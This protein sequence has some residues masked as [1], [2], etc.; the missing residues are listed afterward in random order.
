MSLLIATFFTT[1]VLAE[2]W[3]YQ[4]KPTS[5]VTGTTYRIEATNPY[6]VKEPFDK[7]SLTFT[8]THDDGTTVTGNIVRQGTDCY[9]PHN[10]QTR[11]YFDKINIRMSTKF[12]DSGQRPKSLTDLTCTDYADAECPEG[13]SVDIFTGECVTSD[14]EPDPD[15][16]TSGGD[17]GSGDGSDGG[18]S[19]GSGSS[20]PYA[21]DSSDSCLTQAQNQ[22]ADGR[23]LMNYNYLGGSVYRF[24][25]GYQDY[26]CGDNATWDKKHQ[27]C[28]VDNDSDGTP[29]PFDPD[30]ND[31]ENTG[32]RD[33]DGVVD[34]QDSHPDDPSKWN[35]NQEFA[36][37]GQNVNPIG[38]S[39]QFDDSAI[40]GAINE[41]TQTSNTTNSLLERMSEQSAIGNDF[42]SGIGSSIDELSDALK[43]DSP[44]GKS[45][46]DL[47]SEVDSALDELEQKAI[48]EFGKEIDS[49]LM[50]DKDQLPTIE[51]AFGGLELEKCEDI[52]NFLF[53]IE[54]CS[55][56]PRITPILYWAFACFT[57]IACF[58]TV[59][60]TLK[61][62]T[63]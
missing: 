34:S 45:S 4:T 32:D 25:C 24:Q 13:K 52:S 18:S 20:N 14:G 43:S 63:R 21:C 48:D 22:C 27:T 36:H 7:C 54:L 1:N 26:D 28:Q 5:G 40:V 3:Y 29:D 12:C 6:M 56:A 2:L 51:T 33:S 30:P 15:D 61:K 42:L 35:E 57:L 11:S 59:I 19:D 47:E 49:G 53:T 58:H 50:V 8:A 10:D 39:E 23:T 31:P 16:D 38:Q 41:V 46:G 60:A 9:V 37:T 62:D 17:N 44:S 55:L